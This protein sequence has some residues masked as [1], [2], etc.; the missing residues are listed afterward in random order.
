MRVVMSAL[1][2]MLLVVCP[3]VPTADAQT[4]RDARVLVTVVDQGTSDAQ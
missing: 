1:T 4:S 3:L 2:L